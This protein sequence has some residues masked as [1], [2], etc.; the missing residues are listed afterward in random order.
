M[1]KIEFYFS[2]PPTNMQVYISTLTPLY[3][4]GTTYTLYCIASSVRPADKIT[5]LHLTN[6]T[7]KRNMQFGSLENGDGKTSQVSGWIYVI[8]TRYDNGKRD[9]ICEI[10]WKERTYTHKIDIA[11]R[12]KCKHLMYYM[13]F[14]ANMH[15]NSR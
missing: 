13:A 11:P 9:L 8:L 10:I 1:H 6:N 12:V 14:P 15:T 2:V 5:S 7:D 3:K 4:E